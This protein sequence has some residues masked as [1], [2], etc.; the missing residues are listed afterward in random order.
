ME[1][2]DDNA[3]IQTTSNG[4]SSNSNKFSSSEDK[5]EIPEISPIR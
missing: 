4:N 2:Q 3:N 5:Y 1:S